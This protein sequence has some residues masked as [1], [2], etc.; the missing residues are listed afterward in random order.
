ML[1]SCTQKSI[2]FIPALPTIQIAFIVP[3]THLGPYLEI[4]KTCYIDRRTV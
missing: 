3:G 4:D 1:I 2:A